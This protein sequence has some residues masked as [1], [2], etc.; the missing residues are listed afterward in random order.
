M[1]LLATVATL[2][3][4]AN[5]SAH[6]RALKGG[7][8]AAP[9]PYAGLRDEAHTL[10]GPGHFCNEYAAKYRELLGAAGVESRIVSVYAQYPQAYDSHTFV[11]IKTKGGW[12]IQDPTFE[13]WWEVNGHAASAA[14]LQHALA[15]GAIGQVIWHGPAGPMTSYYVNPL[16]LFRTVAYTTGG[17]GEGRVTAKLPDTYYASPHVDGSTAQVMVIHGGTG[18][19]IGQ[20]AFT[21]TASGEWVSPIGYLDGLELTGDGPG[22]VQ[23]LQVPRFPASQVAA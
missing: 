20:Y 10:L 3:A 6:L 13:G 14:D 18:W 7:R 15:G 11:E 4:A 1:T 19:Q 2:V 23:E 5:A 16:L 12:V 21:K 8:A 9:P 17:E 22:A